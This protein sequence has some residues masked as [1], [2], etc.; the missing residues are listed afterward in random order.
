MAR[1]FEEDF[2]FVSRLRPEATSEDIYAACRDG[3]EMFCKEWCMSPDHDL[4]IT[5]QHGFT[6]MHYATIHGH[7]GIIDVFIN[8]GARIDIINMGGDTLLHIA[9]AYGKYDIV[10]K[11]LKLR[12]DVDCGNEHGNT[13]LHYGSFWNFIGICEILVK[14]GA[15]VA[16]SNKYGDTPLSKAR[17]RLR[18]KLEA[19]ASELGQSLVIV[20]HKKTNLGRRNDFMEF[21][22]RQ[23]EVERSQVITSLRIGEGGHATTWKGSWSGHT[24]AVRTLK[25][26][27]DVYRT[28]LLESFP[29]EYMKL[30]VF[31][32]ENILPLLA[33]ITSPEIHTISM[34]M[35]LGSLYHVLHDLDSEVKINIR[36]GVKFAQDICNGMTYL[37]SMDTLINRF[38]LSPHHVFVSPLTG[39]R[40]EPYTQQHVI[41]LY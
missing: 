32:N 17:P 7:T 26:K 20:P 37:H 15:L 22:Q 41:F 3:D 14:H 28:G 9:A 10:Q 34:F 36:E 12:A 1:H 35:R 33:V 21:K 25:I 30:R 18:K 40:V 5:D 16:M 4:N 13:P 11:L 38:D 31:N 39:S 29:I 8:R 6:P 19:M 24:V 27:G 23:P 2:K